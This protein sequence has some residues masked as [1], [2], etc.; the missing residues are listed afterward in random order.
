MSDSK[1]K[2]I[3]SVY[4]AFGRGDVPFI[5]SQ[6]RADARWDFNVTRSDVPWHVPVTGPGEVPKFLASFM[7]HV[8]LEAFEPRQFVAMGDE[9]IAHIRL[10]YTIRHTGARVDEEQ[11]HWWTVR[12]GKI[13]RLRHFEDTAQVLAAWHGGA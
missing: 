8:Q 7:D 1:V 2:L 13:A 5:C 6:V 10:A 12:E 9:V 3:Q 4:E 11:L